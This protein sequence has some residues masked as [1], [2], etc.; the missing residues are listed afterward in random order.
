MGKFISCKN[1]L[2][3][4]CGRTIVSLFRKAKTR[5]RHFRD[6][7][8]FVSIVAKKFDF[9]QERTAQFATTNDFFRT[10]ALNVS[11]LMLILL[12]IHFAVRYFTSGQ[13]ENS[14]YPLQAFEAYIVYL[15]QTLLGIPVMLSDPITLEY[16]SPPLVN[17][18]Q[19]S[20]V[21]T[22]VSEVVFLFVL[23]LWFPMVRR[24][25]KLKWAAILG[26]VLFIINLIRI[27]IIYPLTTAFGDV[28]A[29]QF[30]YYFWNYG[31]L[32]IVMMMFV[33]WFV[34]VARKEVSE[35]LSNVGRNK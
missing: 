3:V 5:I 11:F 32:I 10:F 34:L 6:V 22:G 7:G 28:F 30:H 27:V 35:R 16:M 21:C 2:F 20:G 1:L 24:S 8:A 12:P 23:I 33:F 29:G 9:R 17:G 25:V 15:V 18:L 26:T 14:L 13:F 4:V 19:I 31:Q